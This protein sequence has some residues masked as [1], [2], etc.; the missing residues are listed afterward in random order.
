MER[1]A[2]RLLS[3]T[4]VAAMFAFTFA[5]VHGQEGNQNQPTAKAG[6]TST[7]GSVKTANGPKFSEYRG[8]RIGMSADNTRQK[9]GNPRDKDKTQD[10]F[11]FSKR[12]TAQVFYDNQQKVY[13]ISIDYAGGGKAAPSPVDILGKDITAKVDGSMYQMQQYPEVGYWVSYNRTA[14]DS[15]LV[16]VTMQRITEFK[17]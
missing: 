6:S 15:A 3:A 4:E 16:T 8:V 9:L 1:L 7:S 10:L 17:Q 13:A 2:I 12:E 14:G 5:L 11:V